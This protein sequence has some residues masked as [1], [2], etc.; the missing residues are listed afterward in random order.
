[1]KVEISSQVRD[2]VRALPPI[3]RSKLRAALKKLEQEQGDIKAL[4]GP[5]ENYFRLR[6]GTYRVIFKYHLV[7]N[8][9]SIRCDFAEKRNIIYEAFIH[10]ID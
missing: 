7:G 6:I 2:F 1:M 8:V 9:R 10:L 4:E 3:P 5:L